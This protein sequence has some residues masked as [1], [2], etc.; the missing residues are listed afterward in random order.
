MEDLKHHIKLD[1]EPCTKDHVHDEKCM[2]SIEKI[3]A[4]KTKKKD[5]VE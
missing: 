2:T 5:D 3:I 1:K 4:N